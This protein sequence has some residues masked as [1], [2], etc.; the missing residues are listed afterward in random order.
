MSDVEICLVMAFV[1]FVV[2]VASSFHCLFFLL[3]RGRSFTYFWSVSVN[4]FKSYL[5]FESFDGL[6]WVLCHLG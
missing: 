1:V 3:L 5:I 6:D 2:V 4:G